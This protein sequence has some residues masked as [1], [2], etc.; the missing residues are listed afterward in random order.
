MADDLQAEQ[1]DRYAANIDWRY[2]I[3][4]IDELAVSPD[5]TVLRYRTMEAAIRR[6]QGYPTLLD[7]SVGNLFS[8]ATSSR[9]SPIHIVH[10]PRYAQWARRA[11]QVTLADHVRLTK[12]FIEDLLDAGWGL[13]PA[14]LSPMQI[15][16]P[17]V[18]N[19]ERT[20]SLPTERFHQL[21]KRP[22]VWPE[23]SMDI[24]I[25]AAGGGSAG[26]AASE[27]RRAFEDLF[28]GRAR[29]SPKISE[30]QAPEAGA[31]NLVLLNG[32]MDLA[33]RPDVRDML[34]AAESAGTRFKLATPGS[35]GSA[36][37]AQNIVYDMFLI[38]G[39]RPWVPVEQQQPFCSVDAG[40][41]KDE[42]RSRW[43]KVE[44]N[45]E[46]LIASVTV[47]DT[48]LA[49][50][51]PP[52]VLSQLWPSDPS[53]LLCRDGKL[54]QERAATEARAGAERRT[55]VEAKKSPRALLWR[56]TEAGLSP[57]RFGDAL[58]DDHGDILL[59]TVKQD[60]ADYIHPM[61]LTCQ[62]ADLL[63]AATVFLHQQAVPPLSLFRQS[64][65][66]GALYFADLVSK[67]TADG[68]PKAIG[69]GFGVPQVVPDRGAAQS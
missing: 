35:V 67:L 34:R 31:V 17:Q 27:V 53:A 49:E 24:V 61:R 23:R 65:L 13:E 20:C 9:P 62:G 40:H 52:G 41:Q 28:G 15:A 3:C 57:A 58:V 1:P 37:P 36:Y 60:P 44:T 5:K 48:P 64:R 39:G 47:I 10:D 18:R 30:A 32:Q 55:L 11:S 66:P 33:A 42:A 4:M 19:G 68:W 38:A 63:E 56:E 7:L 59:Q 51:M 2:R 25:V 50:H 21:V 69:R 16:P 14:R 29:W 45:S 8:T 46:Q 6:R 43:T 26:R 22:A 54:S 12:R